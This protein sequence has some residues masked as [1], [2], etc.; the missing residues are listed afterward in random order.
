LA[1]GK[2]PKYMHYNFLGQED[3]ESRQKTIEFRQHA[4]ATDGTAVTHWIRVIAGI[5]RFCEDGNPL[6]F[7][8]LLTCAHEAETWEYE[9]DGLDVAQEEEL[10]HILAHQDFTI[11]DLLAYIGLPDQAA[12]Y[13]DKWYRHVIPRAQWCQ[14]PELVWDYEDTMDKGSE[15]YEVEDKMRELWEDLRVIQEAR[16][17]AGLQPL[18]GFDEDHEMWPAHSAVVQAPEDLSIA[19]SPTRFL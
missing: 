17:L 5:V 6:G 1:Y 18:P 9:N 2:D 3:W 12:Y 7:T 8:D 13:E 14:E 19:S 10:G 15:E 16:E 4:G 11:I